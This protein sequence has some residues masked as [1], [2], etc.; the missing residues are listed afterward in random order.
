[1]GAASGA[2]T[3]R[4][5]LLLVA[6]AYFSESMADPP[7]ELEATHADLAALVGWLARVE[8][9]KHLRGTLAEAV[10]AIDDGLAGEAVAGALARAAREM[11]GVRL[12]SEDP[13]ELLMQRYEALSR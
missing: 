4:L 10:D 8:P 7:S 3:D 12:E 2:S 9:D 1:M 11:G 6:I 13:V 5:D